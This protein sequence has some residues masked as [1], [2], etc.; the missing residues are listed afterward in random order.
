MRKTTLVIL[1]N[2]V[3]YF[4]SI[5]THFAQQQIA[6][7]QGS[8]VRLLDFQTG[9][10]VNPNFITINN[11]GTPKA[12][13]QVGNEIWITHQI[14]D[15][16]DRHDLNGNFISSISGGLDNIRGLGIVNG[17]E[18]W[19]TN[20][21]TQNGAP[22]DAIVKFDFAGNNL[23][24]FLTAP[25][26]TSP[27]DVVDN[28]NG[29]VFISYSSSNNIERRDYNGNFLG[30]LV[31]TGVVSFI[32]QLSLSSNNTLLAGVFS[33]NTASGNPQGV[34]RFSTGNGTIQNSYSQSG[35]RGVIEL[36]NGNILFSNG[37]GI[38]RIDVNSSTSSSLSSGS[39]QYF[40]LVTLVNCTTPDTPT[41]VALQTFDEGATLAD[42]VVTPEDVSWFATEADAL[43]GANP[44]PS[45]TLLV[46]G[47]TYY[48]V[49]IDGA[50]LSEPFAVTISLN[51]SLNGLN[52]SGI[53]YYPNP[54][55]GI[56]N[57]DH[58]KN[59]TEITVYN[60]LGQVVLNNKVQ[61][62]RAIID[63]SALPNS[64]YKLQISSEDGIQTISV[65]KK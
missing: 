40:A 23:G 36:G 19:V 46:N 50:C 41:G 65:S 1:M 37:T 21:G 4:L 45:S 26:S 12:I 59:I 38:F 54:T 34:Y 52:T 5:Q 47:V 25:Q 60:L 16:I 10:V 33:N 63:L 31:P 2:V 29:E 55:S 18:V 20:A 30:N 49:A 61:D 9:D 11:P 6:V 24:F 22:G 17:T 48:A 57:I 64:I 13:I 28:K 58:Q 39:A 53:V 15:R 7:I 3:I 51:L 62:Q 14:G 35:V 44:L 32:Q 27:F 8:N 43:T 56:L 42:I